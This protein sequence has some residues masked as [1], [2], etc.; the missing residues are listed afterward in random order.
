MTEKEY[1]IRE[2]IKKA[3]Q[4]F[5]G[6]K[7]YE[8][9]ISFFNVLDYRSNKTDMIK[10]NNFAGFLDAFNISASAVN[11]EKALTSHWERSEFIF[12]VADK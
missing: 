2:D 5:D 6:G 9:A 3:I 12:Q 10:P 11:K 8:S 1:Q 4:N 7:L